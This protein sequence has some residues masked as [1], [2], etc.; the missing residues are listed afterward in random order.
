LLPISSTMNPSRQKQ[1]RGRSVGGISPCSLQQPVEILLSRANQT[2][3]AN[4]AAQPSSGEGA[5]LH[6]PSAPPKS[7]YGMPPVTHE[8][9]RGFA[10]C[11][12][13][14]SWAS[15]RSPS[16]PVEARATTRRCAAQEFCLLRAQRSSRPRISAVLARQL[17]KANWS[18]PHFCGERRRTASWLTD[19]ELQKLVSLNNG[20]RCCRQH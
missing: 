7:R 10:L 11:D 3:R 2:K 12:I 8:L 14:R 19:D 4:I 5:D 15:R 1:F 18:S 17:R 6:G 13:H 20:A 9:P 16:F